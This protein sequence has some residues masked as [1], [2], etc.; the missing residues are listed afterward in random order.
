MTRQ[1]A[2]CTFAALLA[3]VVLGTSG[4]TVPT[5]RTPVAMASEDPEALAGTWSLVTLEGQPATASP[6]GRR[7][8][9]R[10]DP[11]TMRVSGFAGVNQFGGAY[12]AAAGTLKFAPLIMTKMAGPPE[13]MDLERRYSR[14]LEATTGWRLAQD[15]LE[16]LAGESV[17]ARLARNE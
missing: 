12:E 11:E 2:F 5:Q 1:H 3:V 14:A 4:C 7:P 15:H 10:F 17:V 16:L 8:T 9:L 6:Q 13:Q